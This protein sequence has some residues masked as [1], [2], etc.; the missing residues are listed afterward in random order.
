MTDRRTFV[1]AVAGG[2]LA[3]PAAILAQPAIFNLLRRLPEGKLVADGLVRAEAIRAMIA[4]PESAARYGRRL[5]SLLVLEV[6]Y[7]VGR[8]ASPPGVGLAEV[9]SQ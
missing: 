6:W 8:I 3:A 5:W 2:L 1:G 9:I 7:G 4:T